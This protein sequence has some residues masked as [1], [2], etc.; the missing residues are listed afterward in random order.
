MLE[1]KK[2]KGCILSQGKDAIVNWKRIICTWHKFK[3]FLQMLLTLDLS[4]MLNHCK[5][6]HPEQS[7]S[8][9]DTYPIG[10]DAHNVTMDSLD[11]SYDREEIDQNDD[12]DDL[13]NELQ[14]M[15]MLNNKC[16]TSFAKPEFLK[17]SQRANPHLY[18]IGCYNDNLALMLAPDSNKVI[19]LEKESRSKLSNLI[20]PF[21]YDKLNNLYDLFVP[22]R[23]KSS[24][25]RYFSERSRLS[26]INVNNGKSKESFNKQSTLL[27]KR[28]D[29]SILLDKQCQSS[30]EIFKVKSYVNTII[31]CVEL[32]KQKIANRT[33][34][35]YID[36]LIQSTIESNFCPVISRISAGLN[37]FHRE[38]YYADHMNAILGVYTELDE[39][40]NLQ[41]DY[42]EM[43]EKC[44]GLETEISKSKMILNAKTLNVK[45]VSAMC[46]KCALINKHKMCV[47]KSV[48]KPLQETVSSESN[49]NPK[50]FTRKLYERVS[51]ICSWWY[52]KFTPSGYKWKHKSG[53]ENVNLNRVYYVEGLNHN[54]FSVGQFCDADLEVAFRKSTC[55]IRDLKGNDLLTEIVLFIVDSRCSKNMTGNLKLLINFVEKF[56]G[57]VKF[58]NDQITP[59]LG[60]GDLVQGAATPKRV[61][62]VEGLNHNL[63]S[64]DQFCDADLEVA[65]WKSTCYIRD[66]KGNDLLISSRGTD[67]YSI[68]LQDINCPNPTFLMAKAT[69]SQAWL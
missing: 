56:L 46:D 37:Q 3:R 65:F 39:V 16:Q 21:D 60:Y 59:I 57:T 20:R 48:A 7:K 50:N 14:T 23:E 33:Y 1:T 53:K 68:T 69:S 58:R 13:A 52:S 17:K 61:Y 47:L 35:G 67:L 24:E 51:K 66:L 26:H 44:E 6:A 41:C 19:R 45:S 9:P 32:C 22:Q 54:L 49:K 30:L 64:V 8:V 43:L 25:Q 2:G 18:D 36:P 29:E 63:F 12:D 4:L 10:Q 27:E 15:N 28:M 34:I 42:L 11:M 40:T 62:Y 55:Y 5:S 38:Y 31:S